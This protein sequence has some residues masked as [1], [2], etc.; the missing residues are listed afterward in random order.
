MFSSDVVAYAILAGTVRF[1]AAPFHPWRAA[2]VEQQVQRPLH[3]LHH[4]EIL[5]QRM[6]LPPL[7]V[8]L[9]NILFLQFSASTEVGDIVNNE[10]ALVTSLRVNL[11]NRA[12]ETLA[13]VAEPLDV[14]G[15]PMCSGFTLICPAFSRPTAVS[16][17]LL[18]LSR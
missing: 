5:G 17:A 12:Q 11:M 1:L 2:T 13:C 8:E 7:A 3:P 15:R 18:R 9:R 16:S 4:E 14:S 6:A 10:M